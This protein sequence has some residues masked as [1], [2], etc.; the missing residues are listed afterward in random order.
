MNLSEINS[1]NSDA[2][3]LSTEQK[4]K[5]ENLQLKIRVCELTQALA[6]AES[7]IYKIQYDDFIATN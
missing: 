5:H 7:H 4:L 2:I 3:E 6:S 1:E